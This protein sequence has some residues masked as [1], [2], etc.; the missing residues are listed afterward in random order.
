MDETTTATTTTSTSTTAKYKATSRV[1]AGLVIFLELLA[2]AGLQWALTKGILFHLPH[3][4]R[5]GMLLGILHLHSFHFRNVSLWLLIHGLTLLGAL[6][7]V[8]AGSPRWVHRVTN[9]V[10]IWSLALG[11]VLLIT[12]VTG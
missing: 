7:V 6:S 8:A 3:G 5:P 9:G 11:T 4:H 1:A 2:L 10:T 12:F